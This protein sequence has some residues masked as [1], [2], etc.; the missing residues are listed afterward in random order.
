VTDAA[1]V[2]LTRELALLVGGPEA[3]TSRHTLAGELLEVATAVDDVDAR[4]VA[5]HHQA[6]AAELR[7]DL[8]A[9]Q[10]AL[11]GLV[12][13]AHGAS[14]LGDAL[15]LD[16]AV[17]MAVTQGRFTDAA[18]TARLARTGRGRSG[19]AGGAVD[20]WTAIS[21]TPGSLA[22]R[23][24]LVAGLLR[25]SLWPAAAETGLEAAERSLLTL[26]GGSRGRAH[27]TVRAY[28]TGAESLPADDE[29]PHLM[30][31]LALGAVE[32]GDRTTAEALRTRLAPHTGMVCGVGY[33][34]FAGP[35][36]FHLGRLAVVVGD[37]DEAENQLTSAVAWLDEREAW[38]WAALAKQSLARALAG[39]ARTGD[40]DSA[41]ALL[42]EA[43]EALANTGLRHRATAQADR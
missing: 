33:R 5:A 2:A 15:L 42:A 10:Q 29:W 17:A 7:G 20:G 27:L 25:A 12:S 1:L 28:A 18:L 21:P 36:S 32:L 23:Q 41:Q 16:H 39:R 19:G 4:I 30:G 24:L 14:P 35:V 43:N 11:A 3:V 26:A 31:V 38:P 22:E 13:A 9:R 6:M 40:R 8:A 37:W 34:T